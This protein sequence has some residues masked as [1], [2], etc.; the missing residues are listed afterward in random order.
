MKTGHI[1]IWIIHRRLKNKW[2]LIIIK[3]RVIRDSIQ[4]HPLL[5]WPLEV[6]MILSRVLLRSTTPWNIIFHVPFKI[7]Q[8]TLK[9]SWRQAENLQ[10]DAYSDIPL[11]YPLFNISKFI[12]FL[13]RNLHFWWTIDLSLSNQNTNKHRFFYPHS[14]CT[15]RT[16]FFQSK[17]YCKILQSLSAQMTCLC[18]TYV[19]RHRINGTL[20]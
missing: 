8:V 4:D 14:L 2:F 5:D 1:K 7:M 9:W 19:N 6:W 15:I 16:D 3:K 17:I 12:S 13:W 10:L 11:K 20:L 18:H